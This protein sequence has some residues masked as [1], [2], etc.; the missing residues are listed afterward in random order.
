VSSNLKTITL[1]MPFMDDSMIDL[2][3]E[4][5]VQEN[6]VNALVAAPEFGA[7]IDRIDLAHAS[8]CC[9]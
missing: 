2:F 5:A 1:E 9:Q 8:G 4:D 3:G 6:I 7:L